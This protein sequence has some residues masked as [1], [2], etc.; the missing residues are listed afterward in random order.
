MHPSGRCSP[1]LLGHVSWG[2]TRWSGIIAESGY[3]LLPKVG[4]TS[5]TIDG[6]KRTIVSLFP[7]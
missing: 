2:R 5:L 3:F 4:D 6:S 1:Y 7:R